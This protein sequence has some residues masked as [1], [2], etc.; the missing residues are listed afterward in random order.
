[1][2]LF[3]S[4]KT[5]FRNI[6]KHR[7]HTGVNLLCLS[8]GFLSLILIT[9]YIDHELNYDRFHADS[10]RI[11][12][13]T[14]AWGT[15][16][17]I[18]TPAFVPKPWA[19]AIADEFP[20]IESYTRVQKRLRF[21]PVVAYGEEKFFEDG[22]INADSSF[23]SMFN[24]KL[25]YGDPKTA[26][27]EPGSIVLTQSKAEKL[28]GKEDPLDKMISF[29][30]EKSLRVTGVLEPLPSQSHLDFNFILAAESTRPMVYS[31]FKI[32]PGTDI[33]ALEAKIGPFLKARFSERFG[34]HQY[35]P[36]FQRLE[37]IH[38]KSKLTYEFKNNGNITNL[39][40]LSAVGLLILVIACF[41]Y[42]NITTAL[43]SLRIKEFGV[44]RTLGGLR[45]QLIFQSLLESTLISIF[46]YFIALLCSNLVSGSFG[47]LLGR[48]LEWNNFF[49][50]NALTGFLIA[51]LVGIVAGSYPALVLSN[52]KPSEALRGK[53]SS[54]GGGAA[55][56][57]ILLVGQ[58]VI[59]AVLI[60][61]ALVISGQLHML[62]S[63]DLGFDRSRVIVI[64]AQFAEG[65]DKYTSV[66]NDAFKKLSE[67]ENVAFSQT[68]PG[69]YSNMAAISYEA[70]GSVED[71]IGTRTI[72]VSHDFVEALGIEMSSGR[73]FSENFASDSAAYVINEAFAKKA[74]W[75]DPLGKEIRMTV[76]DKMKGPVIGVMRDFNYASLHNAV[77]PLALVI[78]PESFQKVVVRTRHGVDVRVTLEKLSAEWRQVLPSYPF[79]F[80][81]MDQSFA[82]LYEADE[83]FSVVFRIFTTIAIVL[84][85]I[86]LYGLISFEVNR[87]MKEIGIRKIAGASVLQLFMRINKTTVIL[88]GI[89]L[90]ISIPL[91]WLL[92][93][94]W[95]TNFA[96]AINLEW[97]YAAVSVVL[98]VT[99]A[100]LTTGY[101]IYNAATKN[102]SQILRSD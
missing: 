49:A 66:I 76:I 17:N 48:R 57:K 86:G 40:L 92:L 6:S 96:Y 14:D 5:A 42:V 64:N 97:W 52:V 27:T 32:A 77:E 78:L 88:I 12:R 102:P 98:L 100:I 11:F 9:L 53:L 68:V 28:F 47:D 87:R 37:D 67:I 84:T 18:S 51:L 89:S 25:K 80:Q 33:A 2:V 91:A 35:K 46:S 95:L 24:F 36:S 19:Q 82:S 94:S 99:I 13:L 56:R 71:K 55:F 54:G 31:Y 26:L 83:Q 81:F 65:L 10:E 43:A 85:C 3:N 21:N 16:N 79:D 70:E 1:M 8:V 93:S 90:P 50:A 38:L 101:R 15:D 44:R 23:F 73:D 58:F 41:N 39:Y 62:N 60:T 4:L 61:G 7:L 72:F 20:E 45:S 74:G 22:F 75:T 34:S 69:D 29:D 63:R 59:S 30:N